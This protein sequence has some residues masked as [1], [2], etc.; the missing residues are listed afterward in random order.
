ML[1]VLLMSNIWA[2]DYPT[3]LFQRAEKQ[4]YT[5][6][7]HL[8]K[9]SYPECISSCIEAMELLLKTVSLIVLGDY[10]EKHIDRWNGE[11]IAPIIDKIPLD[12]ENLMDPSTANIPRLFLLVDFWMKFYNI[13][14][15]GQKKFRIGANRLFTKSE[16]DLAAQHTWECY[17]RV[18]QFQ[19]YYRM[20]LEKIN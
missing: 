12:I 13:A 6:K 2:D 19:H 7:E 9:G 11:D 3:S 8:E 15:Y 14:R 4:Y 5:A 20:Y 17:S 16:A 1:S 10:P 18:S